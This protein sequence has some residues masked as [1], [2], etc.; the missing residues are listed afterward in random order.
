MYKKST[1]KRYKKRDDW[2]MKKTGGGTKK[3]RD[4]R[5]KTR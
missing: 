3:R 2:K 5:K 4:S 1:Y